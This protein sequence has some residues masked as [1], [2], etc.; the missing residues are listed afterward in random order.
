LNLC[1][2]FGLSTVDIQMD[3]QR[4]TGRT[5]EGAV[6]F[7]MMP[8]GEEFDRCY[9]NTYVP[10]I[11]R[12]KL[13]PVRA[14]DIKMP[15]VI[16][17]QVWENITSALA[18]IADV[19]GQNPNVMFELGLALAMNRP[20]VLVTSDSADTIPF[21][22]KSLRHITYAKGDGNWKKKL[23]DELQQYL[24][25]VALTPK[26]PNLFKKIDNITEFLTLL[27]NIPSDA[28][29]RLKNLCEKVNV[30]CYNLDD[31]GRFDK[32][33]EVTIDTIESVRESARH[34]ANSNIS[35]TERFYEN[36]VATCM[37]KILSKFITQYR[38]SLDSAEHAK[39]RAEIGFFSFP[40]ASKGGKAKDPLDQFVE[41]IDEWKAQ[42]W[43]YYSNELVREVTKRWGVIR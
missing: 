16:V 33:R 38:E 27:Y 18:L 12:A 13:H 5:N 42:D 2:L 20:V 8:F 1:T 25:N 36:A 30:S 10:A 24:R 11:K 9:K 21:D 31:S 22:L 28:E 17:S 14:D 26:T 7:V 40:L 29:S 32:I 3:D 41:A 37:E 6:C 15:G 35:I 4:K 43:P 34:A 23:S 19:T 39:V